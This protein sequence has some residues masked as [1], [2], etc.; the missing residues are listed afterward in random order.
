MTTSK[1]IVVPFRVL[2]KKWQELCAS[3]LISICNFSEERELPVP[4][5]GENEF[6]PH[7]LI[8]ILVLFRGSFQNFQQAPLSFL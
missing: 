2:S 7:P 6:G 8:E 3:P 4:L 1:V 5:R